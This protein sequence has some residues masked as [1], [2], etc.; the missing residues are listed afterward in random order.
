MM[1]TKKE[2][3]GFSLFD[4]ANSAYTTVIITAI[5]SVFFVN[6]IGTPFSWSLILCVSYA[7]TL[8]LAPVAGAIA[9]HSANRKKFLF[10]SYVVCVVATAGLYFSVPELRY[11]VFALVII[12]NIGFSLSES[13]VSSFLPALST[14]KTIGRI[15]G[16]AW[17]F[18]YVGGVL[19]LLLALTYLKRAGFS[20]LATREIAP[21]TAIFF[22]L[23]AAPV[24]FLLKDRTTAQV[25]PANV[26]Y[27][28]LGLGRLRDTF[29]DI[30]KYRELFKFLVAFFVYSCGIATVISFAAI[31][32]ENALDFKMGE[33]IMM[34]FVANITAAVGAFFFGFIQ[35]DIGARKTLFITLI[36]W[37]LA[38]LLAYVTHSKT[39]FWLVANLVGFAMGASQSASRSFV[40]LLALEE[41]SAEFFGFWGVASKAAAM[42]GLFSFGLMW[43][44]SGSMRIAI[45]LTL[46]F[47]VAGFV[48]LMFVK[49]DRPKKKWDED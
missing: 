32:A 40:G 25:K 11:L 45:L 2:I 8:I 27:I 22:A 16:Y 23:A 3:F 7:L 21:L 35:D 36:M 44:L 30:K 48:L 34:L 47:F 19:S 12:S 46:V 1:P 18:G 20:N 4:F 24:F 33:T 41:K 15:S 38:V 42:V 37:V 14:P 13:F 28:S 5:Y 26:S 6:N 31:F 39:V 43:K 29:H 10:L 9:D 17:S 49:D